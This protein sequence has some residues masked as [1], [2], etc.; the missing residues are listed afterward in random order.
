MKHIIDPGP[1]TLVNLLGQP[2][3]EGVFDADGQ[4]VIETVDGQRRQKLKPARITFSEF[5][6]GMLGATQFVGEAKG[7]DAAA[8]VLDARKAIAA[9]PAGPGP[10]PLENEHHR[11][12]VRVV[13]EHAFDV[14]TAHNLVP[15]MRALVDAKDE[16]VAVAAPAEDQA[17]E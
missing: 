9:W 3:R 8:L 10:K 16:P 1:I 14:G 6:L 13:K 4:P 17:A 5:C 11:G 12:L 7:I 2:M 15:Y